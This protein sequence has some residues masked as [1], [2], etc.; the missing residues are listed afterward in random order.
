MYERDVRVRGTD[1]FAQIAQA[2]PPMDQ[3]SRQ[4]VVAAIEDAMGEF[5][6]DEVLYVRAKIGRKLEIVDG[7]TTTWIRRMAVGYRLLYGWLER[8]LEVESQPYS[9]DVRRA[10]AA[11]FYFINPFDVIPDHEV[12]RGFSDDAL[13]LHL[14]SRNLPEGW[15]CWN[16]D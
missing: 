15:A 4:L 10:G 9:E 12:G 6:T 11:L 7:S 3:A 14:T 5:S 2:A 8:Q 13:A 1:E 16:G